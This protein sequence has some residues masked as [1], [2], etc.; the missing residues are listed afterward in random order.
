MPW[1]AKL[2][3]NQCG[4]SEFVK[5]IQKAKALI[6]GVIKEHKE[7]LDLENHRDFMDV[8]LNEVKNTTDQSSSFYM[9][10]GGK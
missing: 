5:A 4:W 8:Y 10:S 3:P 1:V 7:T 9:E 2:I 6:G